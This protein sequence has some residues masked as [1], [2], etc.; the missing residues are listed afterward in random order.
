MRLVTTAAA[1]LLLFAMPA[2]AAPRAAAKTAPK[3]AAPA[4]SASFD[5]KDLEVAAWIGGEFGDLD[6]VYLR[7]DAALPFMN[8]APNIRLL[9]VASLGFTHLGADIAFGSISWNIGRAFVAGRGQMELMPKLQA[10]ADIG[11]GF[12]FGGWSS[13]ADIPFVGTI[14]AS[15]TTGGVTMRFA[16]GGNYQVDPRF[17]IAA[18]LGFNPYFGDADTTNFFI[19]VGGAMK[20]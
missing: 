6:G 2:A 19:G 10:F 20:L 12:Y 9:G 14:K 5:M 13:E 18:E 8:L 3:A 16:V 17:S 1:A 7:A 15:D 11:L 4:T